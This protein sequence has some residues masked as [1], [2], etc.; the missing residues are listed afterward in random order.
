MR[1]Y[2]QASSLFWLLLSIYVSLESLRMGIG[3]LREPGMGFMTFGTAL[4]L[5]LFSLVLFVQAHW[6]K[7]A[8]GIKSPSSGIFWGRVLFALVALVIYSAV[9]PTVGYL[10]STF[11]LMGFL[12][13]M[14]KKTSWWWALFSSFLTTLMT[15]YVFSKWLNCQFPDGFFGL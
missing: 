12:F 2:D 8:S 10:I 13:W 15:Y 3:S 14:L 5:G 4:L 11:I 6:R 7:E 9:M 1:T